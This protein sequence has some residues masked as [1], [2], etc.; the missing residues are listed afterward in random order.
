MLRDS[1]FFADLGSAGIRSRVDVHEEKTARSRRFKREVVDNL[2]RQLSDSNPPT[3]TFAYFK[4]RF[5]RSSL[6]GIRK[7]AHARP[8]WMDMVKV[9]VHT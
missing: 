3:T 8:W 9:D 4:R 2:S 1:C 7:N 5:L 6:S